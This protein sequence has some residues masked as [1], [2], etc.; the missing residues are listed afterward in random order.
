MSRA[1]WVVVLVLAGCTAASEERGPRAVLLG[2]GSGPPEADLVDASTIGV[3]FDDG[4]VDASAGMDARAESG[5][6][7][8]S[9]GGDVGTS[10]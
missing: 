9:D 1:P 2:S 6:E 4:G 5:A 3:H 8:G 7:A 10:D